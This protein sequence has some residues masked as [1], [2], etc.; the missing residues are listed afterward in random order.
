MTSITVGEA[1]VLNYCESC[2][3]HCC[4]V[5]NVIASQG[6]PHSIRW[7]HTWPRVLVECVRPARAWCGRPLAQGRGS[8]QLC[9]VCGTLLPLRATPPLSQLRP[10]LLLQVSATGLTSAS[11]LLIL[12]WPIFITFKK[13]DS[14]LLLNFACPHEQK[15]INKVKGQFL[16]R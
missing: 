10:A 4:I 5:K 1:F 9:V 11:N 16:G 13:L 3:S 2:Y 8:G 12:F 6:P 15:L 14:L 7:R